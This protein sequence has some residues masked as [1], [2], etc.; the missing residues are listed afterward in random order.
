ML[1]ECLKKGYPIEI[2]LGLS[3]CSH[4][5][6]FPPMFPIKITEHYRK[7]LLIATQLLTNPLGS[8]I[9]TPNRMDHHYLLTGAK[10]RE[11]MGK[12][13]A[14]MITSDD[15][16]HSRRFPAFS[17][18]KSSLW[19]KI[20]KIFIPTH[21]GLSCLTSALPMEKEPFVVEANG[22]LSRAR[23]RQQKMALS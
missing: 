5:P 3:T 19:N 22:M 12:G 8:E 6:T 16:D 13:I 1:N 23:N 17:T 2:W 9:R 7:L 21:S 18:S 15:W 10:G 14:G 4:V 11:W 20:F